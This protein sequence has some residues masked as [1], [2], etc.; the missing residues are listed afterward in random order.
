VS[1]ECRSTDIPHRISVKACQGEVATVVVTVVRG[2]VWLSIRPLF[3]WEAIMEPGKV[4]EL[5]HALGV[6][7]EEAEKMA[8]AP[9][10]R[11]GS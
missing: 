10:Q 9:E 4:D 11:S 3:T 7:R 2:T 5:I 6:A 8:A 1:E